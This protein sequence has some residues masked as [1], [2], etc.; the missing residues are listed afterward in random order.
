MSDDELVSIYSAKRAGEADVVRILLKDEGIAACIE[1]KQFAGLFGLLEF[2][3]LVKVADE[4]LAKDLLAE[5][6][7]TGAQDLALE[8][9]ASASDEKE[10]S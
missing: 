9:H 3:V 10:I 5:R 4:Q 1:E 7:A 8:Q 2:R 6:S